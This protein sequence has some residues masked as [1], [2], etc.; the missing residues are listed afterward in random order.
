M[1]IAVVIA[2]AALAAILGAL[3]GAILY[4]SEPMRAEP[5]RAR[6]LRRS[7]AAGNWRAVSFIWYST[8]PR[9]S[10]V[11]LMRVA[12]VAAIVI[13]FAV[14]ALAVFVAARYGAA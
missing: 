13:A 5:F 4:L 12:G 8:V 9:P 1:T 6:L 7:Y 3:G 11:L 2:S 10:T 14:L